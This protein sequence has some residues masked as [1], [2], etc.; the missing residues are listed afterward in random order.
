MS[1]V[2][3]LEHQQNRRPKGQPSF[4]VSVVTGSML[5]HLLGL[6]A[7]QRYWVQPVKVTPSAA[8][9]ELT[10]IDGRSSASASRGVATTARPS[11][12]RQASGRPQGRSL[13]PRTT[14]SQDSVISQSNPPTARRPT[15]P[16]ASPRS[17]VGSPP[18]ASR[19][20]TSPPRDRP[21]P[22]PTP[23][24]T[25]PSPQTE[26]PADPVE[27][28]L[29]PFPSAPGNDT[30]LPPTQETDSEVGKDATTEPPRLPPPVPEAGGG[31]QGNGDRTGNGQLLPPE[32]DAEIT[33]QATYQGNDRKRE[34]AQPID[35]EKTVRI[36]YPALPQ[37]S[38]NLKLKA[39]LFLNPSGQVVQIGQAEISTLD[40]RQISPDSQRDAA[41]IANQVFASWSFQ[42]ARDALD[43]DPNLKP[44]ASSIWVEA[45]IRLLL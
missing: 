30:P 4:W 33:V 31:E 16:T 40:G 13:Q 7:L 22:A 26:S 10:F 9:I 41:S 38:T 11:A 42:P 25:P 21:Q 44:V 20:R 18:I 1:V 23:Q 35:R 45:H 19:P 14:A 15:P 17:E 39:E 2:N 43:G 27:D 24:N 32:G 36:P 8:P 37:P 34:Q 6:I 5:L 12:Q 28:P 29:V 3:F